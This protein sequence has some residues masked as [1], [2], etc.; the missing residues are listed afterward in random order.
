MVATVYVVKVWDYFVISLITE[1]VFVGLLLHII[2]NGG[3]RWLV[4]NCILT[5]LSI[6]CDTKVDVRKIVESLEVQGIFPIE[7]P[8]KKV[9]PRKQQDNS[10]SQES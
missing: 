9:S 6:S 2:R 8:V 4:T 3:N 7:T 1:V 10:E 5:I